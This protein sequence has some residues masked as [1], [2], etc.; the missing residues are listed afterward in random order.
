MGGDRLHGCVVRDSRGIVSLFS[1][2]RP[3][4]SL[5][6]PRSPCF[7]LFLLLPHAD[8]SPSCYPSSRVALHCAAL[9]CE[10]QL[11][12][13]V[14]LDTRLGRRSF[15]LPVF[16]PARQDWPVPSGR[17]LE[18]YIQIQWL[19]KSISA[20]KSF[21]GVIFDVTRRCVSFF[22]VKCIV[23]VGMRFVLVVNGMLNRYSTLLLV[24]CTES[25]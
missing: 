5:S 7:S 6:P 10:M 17:R 8:C 2:L 25:V 18:E 20:H 12:R 16:R 15:V 9:H 13:A 21:L 1:P 22:F 24:F 19:V 23:S 4:L 11:H 14:R 3:S